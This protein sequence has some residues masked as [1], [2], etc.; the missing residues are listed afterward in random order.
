MSETNNIEPAADNQVVENPVKEDVNDEKC[1]EVH[2][3]PEPEI[4]SEDS[5]ESSVQVEITEPE[6]S[7]EP[8]QDDSEQK[9]VQAAIDELIAQA[10][11]GD[12]SAQL[13]MG[14]KYWKG[15]EIEKDVEKAIKF[16][17]LAADQD[18]SDA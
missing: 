3:E 6:N 17:T 4:S 11:S 18:I 1:S 5:K 15:T 7:S 9:S 16:Y 13:K 8:L 14:R 2:T 12:A 10:E